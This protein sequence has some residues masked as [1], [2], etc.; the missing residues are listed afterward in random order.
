[1]VLSGFSSVPDHLPPFWP[2]HSPTSL[3]I[4]CKGSEADNPHK[5]SETS[6][7]PGRVAYQGPV[8]GGGTSEHLDHGRPNT[9]LRV[10]NQSR[11]L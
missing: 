5:G 6:P 11:E 8:P 10:D 4:D 1:M 9:I 7:K 2:S 3:Y